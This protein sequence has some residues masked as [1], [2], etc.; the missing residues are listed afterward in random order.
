M[1]EQTKFKEEVKKQEGISAFTGGVLNM[2][3]KKNEEEVRQEQEALQKRKEEDEEFAKIMDNKIL[4]E[5]NS[6]SS[7][8]LAKK[9]QIMD[10]W[11]IVI[12]IA[13]I[14]HIIGI[15][16]I[17]FPHLIPLS[18]TSS[19]DTIFGFGTFLIWLSLTMYLQFD[20][21]FNILPATTKIVFM[22]I[23]RQ[24][25]QTIPI[26]IGLTFFCLSYFGM[27]WRFN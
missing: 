9:L 24:F 18:T 22:P 1:I 4:Q 3:K 13:N 5:T 21:D 12:M 27:C 6:W 23:L 11:A 14:F 10:M 2:M 17:L 7:L 16:T 25:V 19:S 15:L 26:I 20:D 8:P